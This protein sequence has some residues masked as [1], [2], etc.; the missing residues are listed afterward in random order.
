MAG[1][2]PA[3]ACLNVQRLQKLLEGRLAVYCNAASNGP[4]GSVFSLSK[5]FVAL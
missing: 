5:D 1:C 2:H 3:C 4:V